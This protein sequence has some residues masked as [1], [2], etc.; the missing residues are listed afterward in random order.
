MKFLR[1]NTHRPGHR[2][3]E[4]INEAYPD[5]FEFSVGDIEAHDVF[6][7]PGLEPQDWLFFVRNLQPKRMRVF[8]SETTQWTTV[9][10]REKDLWLDG[11]DWK[12][13]EVDSQT[14]TLETLSQSQRD[15]L[16]DM[17]SNVNTKRQALLGVKPIYTI[18]PEN[19]RIVTPNG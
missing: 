14:F 17:V 1:V 10:P 18:L 6:N 19:Q 16:Q 12:V 11:D 13:I 8:K 4:I 5:D 15:I 3:G 7:V 9:L 2:V